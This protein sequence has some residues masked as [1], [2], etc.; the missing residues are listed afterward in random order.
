MF[1]SSAIASNLELFFM[2]NEEHLIIIRL[3]LLAPSLETSVIWNQWRK[4]NPEIIPDL[5]GAKLRKFSLENIDFSNCNLEKTDLNRANLKG[6][7]LE[8]ANLQG[9][10]LNKANL[11]NVNLKNANLKGAFVAYINPTH[12][13][14]EAANLENAI[15]FEISGWDEPPIGLE[16]TAEELLKQYAAGRRS[17]RGLDININ[18]KKILIEANLEGADLA[19]TTIFNPDFTIDDL[20]GSNLKNTNLTGC[21]LGGNILNKVDFSRAIMKEV[22]LDYVEAIAANFSGANLKKAKMT[23]SDFQDSNFSYA[24]LRRAFMYRSQFKNCLLIGADLSYAKLGRHS[25]IGANLTNANL[26]GASNFNPE[27]AILNKTILP[28]GTIA[29]NIS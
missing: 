16:I 14:F 17:F 27:N 15:L 2:A 18:N 4:N 22:Q 21:D 10:Y 11:E 6:A 7:N 23:Y 1:F 9:A 25:L 28:D 12:A 13:N 24:D 29:N 5:S 3:G 19:Y 20:T 26:T 8:N